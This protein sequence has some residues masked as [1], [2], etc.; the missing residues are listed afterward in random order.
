[1]HVGLFECLFLRIPLP[2]V[3]FQSGEPM[4]LTAGM[5]HAEGQRAA[6][7]VDAILKCCE[8]DEEW[9]KIEI[10]HTLHA[11]TTRAPFLNLGVVWHVIVAGAPSEESF[12]LANLFCEVFKTETGGG[13]MV[14]YQQLGAMRLKPPDGSIVANSNIP[15]AM[16]GG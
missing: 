4:L 10:D 6:R 11:G 15:S 13:V 14:E 9:V 12:S 7:C 2:A 16:H 5:K 1:M 8:W 3:L